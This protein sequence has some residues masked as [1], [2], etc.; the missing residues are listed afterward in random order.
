MY[1]K[2]IALFIKF[3]NLMGIL[4]LIGVTL[5]A[6]FGFLPPI[7][8]L[9]VLLFYIP[10]IFIFTKRFFRK[11]KATRMRKGRRVSVLKYDI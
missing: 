11:R 4:C 5:L 2:P 9:L 1:P 7:L 3:C 8:I 10:D 6:L